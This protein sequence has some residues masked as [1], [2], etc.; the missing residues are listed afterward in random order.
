M[1]KQ[2]TVRKETLDDAV[3]W[4]DEEENPAD[5]SGGDDRR[6]TNKSKNEMLTITKQPTLNAAAGKTAEYRI[7]TDR[8]ETLDVKLTDAET[9]ELLGTKR[10]AETTET[11]VDAAPIVNRHL[12]FAPQAGPTGFLTVTD[13]R[14]EVRLTAETAAETV[15]S[16]I[17]TYH[18]GDRTEAAPA[19]L[20]TMPT[21]RLIAPGECDEVTFLTLDTPWVEVTATSPAGTKKKGYT[22]RN[23]IVHVFRLNTADYPEAERIVLTTGEGLTVEYTVIVSPAGARRIAW[24]SHAGSLEHYT[25]PTEATVTATTKKNRIRTPEGIGTMTTER[26]QRLLLRSAYETREVL[27]ALAETTAAPQVWLAEAGVYTPV[28]V[29]TEEAV[30][31]RHGTLNMLELEIGTEIW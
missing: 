12:N 22:A 27:E 30:L 24:R 5:G 29:L 3:P 15:A 7:E 4:N 13:R 21:Q 10:Y 8:A 6:R 17:C 9:G 20:T 2:A 16:G 11:T 25:F 14:R 23:T 28:E 18:A 1:T 26:R 31:H 19:L